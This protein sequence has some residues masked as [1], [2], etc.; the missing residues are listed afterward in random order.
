MP[1]P[2]FLRLAERSVSGEVPVPSSKP[3]PLSFLPFPWRGGGH[4]FLTEIASLVEVDE[5]FFQA[6]FLRQL[7]WSY[8]LRDGDQ[9][10]ANSQ[11]FE[12]SLIIVPQFLGQAKSLRNFVPWR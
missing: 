7:A 2:F 6:P 10:S 8:L 11:V 9:A 1:P 4:D 5:V 12:F 3:E